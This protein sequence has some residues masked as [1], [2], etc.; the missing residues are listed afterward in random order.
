MGLTVEIEP[1]ARMS[2][3]PR[4]GGDNRPLSWVGNH[5]KAPATGRFGLCGPVD[6]RRGPGRWLRTNSVERLGM[7]RSAFGRCGAG[8]A[9]CRAI[10]V[11][12]SRSGTEV[13]SGAEA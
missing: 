11:R 10:A 7:A 3:A 13:D 6:S 8:V 1:L 2:D 4:S 5:D 9:P 12:G